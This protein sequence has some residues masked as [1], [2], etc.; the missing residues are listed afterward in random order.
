MRKAQEVTGHDQQFFDEV[1]A[2]AGQKTM[3]EMGLTWR[4][5]DA[6]LG[7]VAALPKGDA[8]QLAKA[9][10]AGDM[11]GVNLIPLVQLMLP[12]YSGFGT[13][14]GAKAPRTGSNQA[15]WRSL[16]GFSSEAATAA[17][18][19]SVAEASTGQAMTESFLTYN[20]PYRDLTVNDSASLK[21]TFA[22]R[23]FDDPLQVAIMNS[24]AFMLGVRER[25]LLYGNV[26]AID[27]PTNV[28]GTAGS[29]GGTLAS[30]SGS[31]GYT[32]SVTALTGRGYTG[33][34]VGGSSTSGETAAG[35]A[36]AI[37]TTG[38]T[39]KITVTWTPSK[40]AAAYNVYIS[41]ANGTGSRYVATTGAT[42]Y[43]VT[44]YPGSGNA[45][46]V[47][48]TTANAYGYN[49]ALAWAQLASVYGNA[50]P[51]TKSY[52]D[53]AGANFTAGDGGITQFNTVLRQL[54]QNWKIAPTLAIMSPRMQQA[55]TSK[56][57]SLNNSALYRIEMASERTGFTGGAFASSLVNPFASDAGGGIKRMIDLQGSPYMPD[58]TVLILSESAPYGTARN[59][60]IFEA[61]QLIP[62]TYFPLAQTTL[63]YPFAMTLAETLIC[64]HPSAQAAI[65][66]INPDA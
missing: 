54:W 65:V 52:V 57:L 59:T 7:K 31:A 17:A 16:L 20:A 2:L 5:R 41:N 46:P 56:L 26:E 28:A 21:S 43:V 33:G 13:R 12:V 51:G 22:A 4:N 64:Y 27:A 63:A 35:T 61:E 39:S 9:I 32:V 8:D 49:G 24:L 6:F 55:L 30:S 62:F 1:L 66:G 44:A 37:A 25:N 14:I 34:D 42:S 48:G 18:A 19:M 40:G 23:G 45:P 15:T 38:A 36:T 29:T 3:N 58:G 11:P 47:T 60:R 50:T 53:A 10:T